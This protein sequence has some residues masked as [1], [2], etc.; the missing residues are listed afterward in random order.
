MG[1]CMTHCPTL[2]SFRSDSNHPL[3]VAQTSSLLK[4]SVFMPQHPGHSAF[5][6]TT[7]LWLP[8]TPFSCFILLEFVSSEGIAVGFFLP[9]FCWLL[10]R[11]VF[12]CPGAGDSSLWCCTCSALLLKVSAECTDNRS[13]QQEDP[14]VKSQ[15]TWELERLSYSF[16][17]TKN[18][19][20]PLFCDYGTVIIL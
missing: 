10:S 14:K 16:D 13:W 1:H 3:F 5:P 4:G 17:I 8:W 19:H 6:Q 7:P 15:L 11:Y 12:H 2:S 9:K 20:D 18:D